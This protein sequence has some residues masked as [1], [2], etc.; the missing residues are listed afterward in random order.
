MKKYLLALAISCSAVS[1][2][3]ALAKMDLLQAFS[4]ALVSDPTYQ[5]ALAQNLVQHEAVPITMGAMLPQVSAT[6]APSIGRTHITGIENSPVNKGYSFGLSVSQTIFDF[7]KFAALSGAKANGVA[8]NA[9]L[10]AVTQE[11]MMRV[12]RAYFAI[13]KD[14]ENLIYSRSAKKAFSR[15][16]DQATQQFKVGLKTNTDVY[17]AEAAFDNAA[18]DVI[19]AETA[20]A[21]DKENLRAITG[22]FYPEL[23]QLSTHFPLITPYPN[24]MDAWVETA[25]KQNWSIQAQRYAA[26]AAMDSIKQQRAG[27]FPVVNLV[28]NTSYTYNALTTGAGSAATTPTLVNTRRT[29]TNSSNVALNISLPLLAGGQTLALTNQAR[30]QYSAALQN[31]ELIVRTTDANT[32]QTFLSIIAGINKINADKQTIKSSQSALDG[33]N[34]AYLAGTETLVNVL[35]QQQNAFQAEK[36]YATDRYQYVVNLLALKQ[37]AGT[38]GQQDLAAVNAWLEDQSTQAHVQAQKAQILKKKKLHPTK[39]LANSEKRKSD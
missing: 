15:Q 29:R 36:N 2:P 13:L 8:A 39:A 16:Y 1:M 4:A 33:M 20:L 17:T 3:Q 9:K 7:G 25:E 12:T 30:Y 37:A 14:E 11:L 21:V 34:E 24:Q 32:R 22:T 5:V 28:G 35:T 18:S 23:K 10:N 27:N 38:L 19:A 6:A 26:L 31:I